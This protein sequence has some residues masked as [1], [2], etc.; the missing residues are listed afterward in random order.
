VTL[1]DQDGLT[2]FAWSPRG[3]CF[4]STNSGLEWTRYSPPWN[5]GGDVHVAFDKQDPSSVVAIVDGVDLY[6][7][8]SGGASW[9]RLVEK[10]QRFDV[11]S[12]NWNARSGLLHIGTREN[13]VYRILLGPAIKESL[14][15]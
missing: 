3:A 8:P 4:R 14:E 15:D 2:Y 5:V 10:G 13:G 6:Y 7:S 9:F 1:D 11:L 12:A